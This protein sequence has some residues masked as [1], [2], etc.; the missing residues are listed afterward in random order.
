[1]NYTTTT[2]TKIS[3]RRVHGAARSHTNTH[4]LHSNTGA[5]AHGHAHRS[6]RN[7]TPS[8]ATD[9]TSGNDDNGDDDDDDHDDD[10]DDDEVDGNFQKANQKV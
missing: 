7:E 10:D 2:A 6:W 8:T 1:M 3:P 4:T 5:R 9:F